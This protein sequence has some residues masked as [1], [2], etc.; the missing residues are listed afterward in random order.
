MQPEYVQYAVNDDN[1]DVIKYVV[2]VQLVLSI[3]ITPHRTLSLPN[4]FRLC[5]AVKVSLFG[6]FKVAT[7]LFVPQ[8][9]DQVSCVPKSVFQVPFYKWL[10]GG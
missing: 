3:I 6:C 4:I 8:I 9:S 7:F 5:T 2:F 1:L 10:F